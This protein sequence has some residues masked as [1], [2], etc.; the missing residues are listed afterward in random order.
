[1]TPDINKILARPCNCASDGYGSSMGRRDQREGTPECLHLQRLRFVDGDY[2]T[3]GAYW[4]GGS[5]DGAIYCAFSPEDTENDVPIMV[6]VRARNREEAK[7]KVLER[8]HR[9]GFTF[10]R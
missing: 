3:G 7:E 6:F 2:D 9:E 5:K 8:L 10:A 1:M 4:G